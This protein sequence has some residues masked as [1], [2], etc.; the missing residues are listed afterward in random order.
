MMYINNF[1]ADYMFQVVMVCVTYSST[2]LSLMI[3]NF[4]LVFNISQQFVEIYVY[5]F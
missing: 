3:V 2:I 5:R 1:C 4:T